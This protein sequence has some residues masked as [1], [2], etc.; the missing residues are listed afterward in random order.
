MSPILPAEQLADLTQNSDFI[1]VDA[2][3]NPNPKKTFVQEHLRGAVFVD[4]N[5]ELADIKENL[6]DGGRH[7]LPEVSDF[8]T[9]L[10]NLGIEPKTHV[11]VYDDQNG[12]NSAAR[13]WW[14]VRA[15]GHEKVQ[16]LEGGMQ[17]AIQVGYSIEKG[18]SKPSP[19]SAY[20]AENWKLPIVSMPEVEKK[21]GKDGTVVIDVRSAERYRGEQEPIDLIAGHIPGAINIPLT[22]NMDA[23]GRFLSPEKLKSK[24][25]SVLKDNEE[26]IVHC[27][28]GVSACHTL[29]AMDYAGLEIPKLYAGSWSEWSRND[30]PIG[31]TDNP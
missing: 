5:L 31:K 13:F 12:A 24:Y 23:N 4:P 20:P 3:N 7:P 14:M 16:V 28:S 9:V 6:A 19:T 30:K 26:V 2:R 25:E 27:G 10:G 22:E 18:D 15:L 1:L 17:A 29:L 8:C 21:A 11:V